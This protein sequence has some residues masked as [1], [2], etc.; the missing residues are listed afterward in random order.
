MSIHKRPPS[1]LSISQRSLKK[2]FNKH[3]GLWEES[4]AQRGRDPPLKRITFDPSCGSINSPPFETYLAHLAANCYSCSEPRKR[5]FVDSWSRISFS[6][7]LVQPQRGANRVTSILNDFCKWVRF[8]PISG[9][10]ARKPQI[11][12]AHGL[13]QARGGALGS[14]TRTARVRRSDEASR[15]G[16]NPARKTR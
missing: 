5:S 11:S 4:R 1:P 14:T 10:S 7:R 3:L 13:G 12:P 9:G 15:K 6:S 16:P 2:S 8:I